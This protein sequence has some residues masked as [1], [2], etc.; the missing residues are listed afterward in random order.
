MIV[1]RQRRVPVAVKPLENF[2]GRVQQA[3]HLSGRDVTVCLVSDVAIARMNWDFRRKRGPTDVL[4]FPGHGIERKQGSQER[5][6]QGRR[7]GVREGSYLG[8]IAISPETAQRNARG[9]ERAL[10]QELHILILHGMLHL[11]GHDHERDHGEM[12]R[13]ESC[14]RRRFGLS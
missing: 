10:P 3:L 12:D 9:S 8:D 4:S 13:L 11:A 5:R 14:L 6:R 2:L 7:M 1:N